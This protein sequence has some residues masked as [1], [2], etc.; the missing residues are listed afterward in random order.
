MSGVYKRAFELQGMKIGLISNFEQII[1]DNQYFRSEGGHLHSLLSNFNSLNEIS[2]DLPMDMIFEVRN[3]SSAEEFA[4]ETDGSNYLLR[5]P[6][7]KWETGLKDK[8]SSIF[9]NMGIFS[10][11]AVGELEKQG[12]FS[13]HSTSFCRPGENRLYLV[14]GGSGAG[15][16]S[17]LLKAQTENLSVFGTE[18]THFRQDGGKINMMMGSLWQNCRMG[19]LVVDFP[20]LLEKYKIRYS[21]D[22]DPWHQYM[23]VNLGDWKADKKQ[24]YDPEIVLLFPRIE[25]ERENNVISRSKTDKIDYK[26][27]GNLADKVSPPSMLYG[28]FFIPSID[29][30]ESQKRRMRAAIDFR[31]AANIVE[32]WEILA[33]PAQ[34]LNGII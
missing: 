32:C 34:C 25:S 2:S 26:L 16:S 30:A 27:Y 31:E 15:K 29:D 28:R 22:G 20:Q 8:R 17:V 3:H 13:F 19:N 14:L 5:G 23:S 33:S 10:K 11:I 24:F 6:V 1:V 7:E 21:G 4:L 9:G 18:L 12:V